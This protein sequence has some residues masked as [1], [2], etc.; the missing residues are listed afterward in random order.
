MVFRNQDLGTGFVHC[1][2]DSH[3]ECVCV[4][5][6]VCS[7]YT[8]I[9]ICVFLHLSISFEIH[10]FI[11]TPSTPVQQHRI[12]SIVFSLSIHLIPFFDREKPASHDLLWPV[13]LNV[14]SLLLLLCPSF[15]HQPPLLCSHPTPTSSPC[16]LRAPTPCVSPP[17]PPST[18]GRCL[19]C[20]ASPESFRK[21]GGRDV[22]FSVCF[23]CLFWGPH[24]QHM[25]VPRLLSNWSYSFGLHHS[26][27]NARSEP[28][29]WPTPRLT[30]TPDPQSTEQGQGSH[31]H[32][33]GY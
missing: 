6:C 32:P 13:L 18:P 22:Y 10:E 27:S 16:S 29:L 4:C 28:S 15:P 21:S 17:Q 1:T 8:Y 20:L 24:Q 19:P 14:T 2:L 23:V 11:P 9:Y 25:E 31:L 5:V 30:T 12:Y 26:H 33:H 7:I 3:C